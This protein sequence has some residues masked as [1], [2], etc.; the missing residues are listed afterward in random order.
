V[1]L[2]GDCKSSAEQE[3]NFGEGMVIM[4]GF[5]YARVPGV[6]RHC[7][8]WRAA[9]YIASI[10]FGGRVICSMWAR[11]HSRRRGITC[12]VSRTAWMVCSSVPLA[13][14]PAVECSRGRPPVS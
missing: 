12:S 13:T 2:A 7:L 4:K 9:A 14:T 11:G 1:T 8:Y 5:F 6:P 3:N 10:V